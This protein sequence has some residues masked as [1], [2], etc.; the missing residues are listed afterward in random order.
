M[1]VPENERCVRIAIVDR[2]RERRNGGRYRILFKTPKNG[3]WFHFSD[4]KYLRDAI[5]EAE[6]L[7]RLARPG[8]PIERLTSTNYMSSKKP[9]VR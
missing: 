4:R 1:F 2:R 3:T 9:R 5:I 6:A 8:T 7:S